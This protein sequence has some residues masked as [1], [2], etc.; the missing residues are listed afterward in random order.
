R[1]SLIGQCDGVRHSAGDPRQLGTM[2]LGRGDLI[3]TEIDGAHPPG[4]PHT[5]SHLR[6]I[7]APATAHF[8]DA[9]TRAELECLH[10]PTPAE[11][12]V[13]TLR[14]GALDACHVVPEGQCTHVLLLAMRHNTSLQPLYYPET[15]S[16]VGPVPPVVKREV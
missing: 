10:H 2:T 16:R 4:R 15:A 9:L 12:Q 7:E 8:Q 13:V 6:G 14:H 1:P 11:H 5:L 3:G